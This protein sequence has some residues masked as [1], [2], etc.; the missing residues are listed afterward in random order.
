[1]GRHVVTGLVVVRLLGVD[2]ISQVALLVLLSKK[3]TV[4]LLLDKRRRFLFVLGRQKE[5][6]KLDP[7]SS[8]G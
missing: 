6:I 5:R 7:R 2:G 3:R 1:M 4:L 8:P